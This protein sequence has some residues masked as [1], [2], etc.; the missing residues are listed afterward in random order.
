[1]SEDLSLYLSAETLQRQEKEKL[2]CPNKSK[3][4]MHYSISKEQT[5]KKREKKKNTVKAGDDITK[6]TGESKGTH[7]E[8]KSHQSKNA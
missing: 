7:P 8:S 3:G 4:Q 6:H 2:S 1:M 5:K